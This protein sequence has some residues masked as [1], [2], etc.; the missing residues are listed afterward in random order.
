MPKEILVLNSGSSSLKFSLFDGSKSLLQGEVENIKDGNSR[1]WVKGAITKQTTL[2]IPD[3][4]SAVEQVLQVLEQY[5]TSSLV[6]IGHRLVFGGNEFLQPIIIDQEVIQK[7]HAL[8]SFAPLHMTEE[9]A[10]IEMMQKHFSEVKQIASFDTCFHQSLPL[11]AQ[12]LGLP[13]ILH[14]EGVRRFGFHGLSFESIVA[15]FETLP[16]KMIIAH[17][18]NGVSLCA[19]EE[20]KSIDTSMGL[21]PLG[22]LPMGTRPGDLDPGAVLY[23]LKQKNYSLGELERVFY[24]ESGLKGVSGVSSD[25]KTLLASKEPFAEKAVELFCY[26]IAKMIGSYLIALDGLDALVFTGG[27]GERSPAIRSR[28]C[29]QLQSIGVFL[30]DEKNLKNERIV[31]KKFNSA[32]VFVIPT[33]EEKI[34]AKHV[35]QSL[36]L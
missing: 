4:K 5:G 15:E 22:G 33:Q 36:G 2:S 3:Q 18:G 9:I 23:L 34:I 30:D 20:G 1:F 32:Q 27:I 26:R 7:L 14:E 13:K 28:I 8:S 12:L 11:K 24:H 10:V 19:L 17:L 21:T 16:K 6:G 35:M 31:S 25:M 29:A